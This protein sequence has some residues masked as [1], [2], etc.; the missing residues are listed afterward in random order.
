MINTSLIITKES[1]I[2]KCKDNAEEITVKNDVIFYIFGICHTANDIFFKNLIFLYRI[3][4]KFQSVLCVLHNESHKRFLLQFY[5]TYLSASEEKMKEKVVII[6]FMLICFALLIICGLR[7]PG[8]R[9]SESI[10]DNIFVTED[11][12]VKSDNSEIT[13]PINIK[14]QEIHDTKMQEADPTVMPTSNPT[15][16]PAQDPT[17]TALITVPAEHTNAPTL[18]GTKEPKPSKTQAPTHTEIPVPS[19][20]EKPQT[21]KPAEKVPTLTAFTKCLHKVHNPVYETVTVPAVG[22]WKDIPVMKEIMICGCGKSEEDFESTDDFYLHCFEND[23]SYSLQQV[24]SGEYY[25]EWIEYIAEYTYEKEVGWI[26]PDCGYF[27]ES[28]NS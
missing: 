26:C 28:I 17:T 6:I 2:S 18:T 20:T 16:T 4:K 25:T 10:I 19:F 23:E 13:V 5:T 27:C 15:F 3:N 24:P 7:K 22:E 21:T 9:K 12:G 11:P 1:K 14:E 8:N